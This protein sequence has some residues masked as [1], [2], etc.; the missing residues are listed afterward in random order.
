MDNNENI[1]SG[2]IVKGNSAFNKEK[3]NSTPVILSFPVEP[4]KDIRDSIRSLGL[5]FNK[6]RKE[7]Y[8][9][10]KD[11]AKLKGCVAKCKHDLE[12]LKEDV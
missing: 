7:W 3:Q 2:W 9:N 4:I 5:R 12:V 8:G 11:V 10:V 6:F 1:V